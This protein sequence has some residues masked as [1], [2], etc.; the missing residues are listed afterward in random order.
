MPA[1]KIKAVPLSTK[2]YVKSQLTKEADKRYVYSSITA[3]YTDGGSIAPL[4][5]D[6]NVGDNSYGERQGDVID[7]QLLKFKYSWQ[8]GDSNNLCRLIIF[9][10]K[11]DDNV[12]A[13]SV[14]NEVVDVSTQGTSAFP[15]ATTVFDQKNFHILYDSLHST[16]DTA[17]NMA[18]ARSIMI[19]GKKMLKIRYTNGATNGH[20]KLYY[21][22]ITDS[23]VVPH[24]QLRINLDMRYKA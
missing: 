21:V 13:P 23:A 4:A 19:Y 11:P 20:N 6:T 8:V 22:A 2:R 3:S 5:L 1:K 24:P 14:L 17:S 15:L 18:T 10:W 9:Q 16:V 7:P 12:Y